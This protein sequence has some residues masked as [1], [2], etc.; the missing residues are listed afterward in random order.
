MQ[1]E[2]VVKKILMKAVVVFPIGVTLLIISYASIYFYS[3]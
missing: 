3:W 2:N 1:K